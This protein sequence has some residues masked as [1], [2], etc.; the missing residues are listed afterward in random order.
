[1]CVLCC[2]SARVCSHCIERSARAHYGV[3][4]CIIMSARA[5][6]SSEI[7]NFQALPSAI[8]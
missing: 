2:V 1:M 4:S 5:P 3:R 8:T 6:L 7:S